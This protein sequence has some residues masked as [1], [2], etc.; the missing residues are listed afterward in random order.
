MPVPR[1]TGVDSVAQRDSFRASLAGG[2]AAA[3][4]EVVSAMELD[5]SIESAP[6]LKACDTDTCMSKIGEL[7]AAGAV[8]RSS[9]ELLGSSNYHFRLDLYDAR[10]HRVASSVDDTCT[11]CTAHEAN[12]ALSR[13]AAAMGRLIPS[14]PVPGASAVVETPLSVARPRH[15]T[16]ANPRSRLFL[17]LGLGS[18]VMGLGTIGG[19]A[20]LIGVDGRATDGF[21]MMGQPARAT[22]HTILPGAVLT[23]VGGLFLAGAGVLLWRA[24]V[25]RQ[26]AVVGGH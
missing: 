16:M 2:L 6:A 19:G 13:T 21:D 20:A 12:E 17:G 23:A 4:H 14:S 9:V 18:L 8:L 5:R 22:L 3:G 1:T 15:A 11:I 26:P 25:A 7:T 24:H 10:A